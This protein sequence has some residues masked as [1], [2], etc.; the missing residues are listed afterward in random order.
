MKIV[1]LDTIFPA[2]TYVINQIDP[3]IVR[4]REK[5]SKS[6]EPTTAIQI[7][8]GNLNFMIQLLCGY[9]PARNFYQ[10]AILTTLIFTSWQKCKTQSS[11]A[12][13]IFLSL[14]ALVSME[15]YSPPPLPVCLRSKKIIQ[16]NAKWRWQ[17]LTNAI[18]QDS[19]P[20][21]CAT[22]SCLRDSPPLKNKWNKCYSL[23]F[24]TA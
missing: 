3:T 18:W 6:M 10:L 5:T 12:Y 7:L 14:W 16:I 2:Q 19:V 9:C 20:C 24:K 22:G 8:K 21:A 15:V 13:W 23:F 11:T 4:F 17:W 1:F